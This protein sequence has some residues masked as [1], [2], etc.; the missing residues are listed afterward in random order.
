MSRQAA[1]G[2]SSDELLA[3]VD[4]FVRELHAQRAP[5]IS[6]SLGSRIDRDLG[7][8]SLGRTELMLRVEQHFGVRLPSQTLSEVDTVGDLADALEQAGPRTDIERRP[9]SESAFRPQVGAPVA[10]RTLTEV[11]DWHVAQHPERVHVTMLDDD[12]NVAGTM[13][14]GELKQAARRIAGALIDRDVLPG[15]RIALMLPTSFDFF[16]AFFGVLYAGAV[17]VPIYPPARMAQ[18]EEHMVRQ[19]GILRN[20]GARILVTV[21]QALSLGNWIRGQAESLES[22]DSVAGLTSQAVQERLPAITDERAT[23][24]IQYTSGSTGDPKGVVLSHANLL[25]NIRALGIAMGANSADVFV[26]WLPLYHDLGLIGAWLGSLYFAAS[27]YVMSPLSFLGRPEIWLWAVHR[28]RA[29]LTAA[30]NFAFELCVSRIADGDIAGLDLSSLRMVA[31]GAEPVSIPTLRGFLERYGRFGFKPGAMVPAYGLAENTVALTFP[32][33]GRAP[34]IDRVDREAL[35]SRG[36]A[37]P[38]KADDPHPL[39]FVSCGLPLPGDE[40]RIVDDAGRELDERFEG[41]LEF[42]GPAATS[43]Y[44]RN[45]VKTRELFRDGWLDSGDQAYLAGGEVYIT[46]RVKDMIIRAGRHIYPQEIEEAV[47]AIPG[48]VKN[49]V[50]AFGIADPGSGT[51]RVVILAETVETDS[52]AREK[53]Q[54]RAQEVASDVLGTP[55]DE[56]VLAPPYSVPKT[57]SGKIRRSAAKDLYLQGR[58]GEPR[59]AANWQMAR[60][61]VAGLVPQARRM[62]R[63]FAA[64]VYAGWWWT[65]VGLAGVLA[66]LAVLLLPRLAWRWAAV[67]L[68][69]RAALAAVGVRV[70]VTGIDHLSVGSAVLAFNHASYADALVLAAALPGTPV[71]AAKKELDGQIFAGPFLRRLGT[72][73]L[74]RYDVVGSLADTKEITTIACRGGVLV[75]FPEGTFTRRPGLTNFYLGTFKVASEA[76]LPVVPGIIRG[77]R[78]MLRSDQWF[79]R[80]ASISVHVDEP[81]P[82]YGT[83]FASLLRLRDRVRSVILRHCGEPDLAELAK[84]AAPAST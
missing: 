58:I 37:A 63:A 66:W 22:V 56:I 30:P 68:L 20:A 2:R 26:S 33:L 32:P 59:L 46:G 28:Y 11:L 54:T 31:N 52:V 12:A 23:A 75:F 39:E 71:F 8:D 34:L 74:E 57:S 25:A 17:P 3:L 62:L 48:L 77:T 50:A 82:P 13:T 14:Y 38:A 27:F 41:R 36:I 53:L 29:T 4:D 24:F 60:L 51:E 81:I 76:G 70:D 49:G 73:F 65:V 21:P 83:D 10:A 6:V 40:V 42:R 1:A 79:P 16:A 84:P 55:A 45:P 47:G 64:L 35:S 78:S 19:A 15:D 67:R 61:F 69:A 7:I 18:L 43:G 72:A 5:A 9:V 80:H 44:F